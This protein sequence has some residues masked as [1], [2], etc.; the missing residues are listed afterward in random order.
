MT[1]ILT[2]NGY[3][4]V[5]ST[6]HLNGYSTVMVKRGETDYVVATWYPAL[7]STWSWGHYDMDYIDAGKVYEETAKR[8]EQRGNIGARI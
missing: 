5:R 4:V 2:L 6:L 8:N 3:P 1:H 7:G